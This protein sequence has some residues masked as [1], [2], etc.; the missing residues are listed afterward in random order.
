MLVTPRT[1]NALIAASFAAV[2][3]VTWLIAYLL[4]PK[5]PDMGGHNTTI[6]AQNVVISDSTI[7]SYTPA[8]PKPAE[9]TTLITK[10]VSLSSTSSF[11]Y[12]LDL[13]ELFKYDHGEAFRNTD[14]IQFSIQASKGRVGKLIVFDTM[15][16][17]LNPTDLDK[18]TIGQ[19][20]LGNGLTVNTSTHKVHAD[21]AAVITM[22]LT[23]PT[24]L[25][26]IDIVDLDHGSMS[27]TAYDANGV[28]LGH[29]H[30]D[31]DPIRVKT[32]QVGMTATTF[33]L[34]FRD[35][36]VMLPHFRG[37]GH[38]ET[39]NT[40]TLLAKLPGTL[41]GCTTTDEE[42]KAYPDKPRCN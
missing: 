23:T 30:M 38:G 15:S 10:S 35:S 3:L 21:G 16:L 26:S 5:S 6:Q 18:S 31:S 41:G 2:I 34:N 7:G 29:L 13:L 12:E 20:S 28:K 14:D 19:G 25:A 1:R 33:V 40:L 42:A 22:T 36:F 27:L 37:F 24:Y 4:T 9:S 17:D 8:A 32:L 39:F 11:S